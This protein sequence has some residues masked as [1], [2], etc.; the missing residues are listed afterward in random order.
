MKRVSPLAACRA[1]V[2]AAGKQSEVKHKSAS[3]AARKKLPAQM[4][5]GAHGE[6]IA[7]ANDVPEASMSHA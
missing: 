3:K 5:R 7:D 1:E 6:N 2:I 4:L